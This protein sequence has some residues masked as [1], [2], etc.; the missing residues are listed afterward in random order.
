[1]GGMALD[2]VVAGPWN[3]RR[4]GAQVGTLDLRRPPGREWG[5]MEVDL[6]E[7]ARL[8]DQAA[9]EALARAAQDRLYA[10]AYR[11]VRDPDLA[12]D[13]MQA[14]LIAMWHDLPALRDPARF[15]SWS[16]RLLVRASIRLARHERRQRDVRRIPAF[17]MTDPL[18][19]PWRIAQRDEIAHA[20]DHLSPEHRAILVLRYYLDQPLATMATV[21]GIPEGTVASRLNHASRRLGE[22]LRAS[23]ATSLEAE[24]AP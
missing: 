12:E 17:E 11:I 10:V 22:V 5:L 21:L 7:R 4:S 13:A 9:F 14:A 16:Y 2:T 3:R 18:D 24:R 1:M 8:G 6:V 15:E 19:A 23:R 20:F